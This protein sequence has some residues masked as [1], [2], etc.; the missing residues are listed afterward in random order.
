[1][2]IFFRVFRKIANFRCERQK[3]ILT[4]EVEDKMELV[5]NKWISSIRNTNLSTQ[6]ISTLKTFLSVTFVFDNDGELYNKVVK[7]IKAKGY[8]IIMWDSGSG[9]DFPSVVL[10]SL[11]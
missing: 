7:E 8:E 9:V 4:E 3:K 2:N 10:K 11:E 1:M 5:K 6:D